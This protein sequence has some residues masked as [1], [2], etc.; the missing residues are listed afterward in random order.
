M[1]ERPMA[2]VKALIEQEGR[3]LF[4]ATRTGERKFWT[5]PGGRVEFG[6]KP[7]EALEREVMEEVSVKVDIGEPEGMYTFFY[8]EPEKQVVLTVYRCSIKEGDV[9]IS[10]N[11]ADENIV[12]YRWVAPGE[13][14]DLELGKGVTDFV[15]NHMEP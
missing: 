6:E 10:S 1:N 7:L 8:G 13:I 9:D 4:I 15:E 11:P 2:A 12:D 14:E 3:Y 5:L